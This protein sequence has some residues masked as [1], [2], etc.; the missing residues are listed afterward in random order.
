[1]STASKLTF[2]ASCAFAVA[3]FVGINYVQK[4][5]QAAIR[6]GPIK[7]AARVAMKEK[8]RKQ[9]LN[10]EE[11]KMQLEL[12]EKYE[13]IQPLNSEVIVGIDKGDSA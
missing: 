10:D 7:D 3:S 1:M 4:A 2:A 13:K 11:H 8:T 12:R 5:E 6:Q 9:K